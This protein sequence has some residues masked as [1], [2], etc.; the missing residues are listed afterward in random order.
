MNINKSFKGIAI[1][2]L[3]VS[4]MLVGC[5]LNTYGL[6]QS[7]YRKVDKYYDADKMVSDLKKL[8]YSDEQIENQLRNALSR[9]EYEKGSKEDE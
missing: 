9:I 4:F 5:T 3:S 8:H 2:G 6:T 1:A 7:E